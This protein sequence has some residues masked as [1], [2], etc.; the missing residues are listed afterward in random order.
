[1][2]KLRRRH[3]RPTD[4]VEAL[5]HTAASEPRP[6]GPPY[7][8]R[9][10]PGNRGWDVMGSVMPNPDGTPFVVAQAVRPLPAEGGRF[11]PGFGNYR[12]MRDAYRVAREALG[13]EP[14]RPARRSRHGTRAGSR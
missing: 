7:M 2:T 8:L 13:V 12:T 6:V 1:M 5:R 4:P 3:A 11:W 10:S 14:D 9:R